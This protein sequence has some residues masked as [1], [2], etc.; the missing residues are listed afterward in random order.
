MKHNIDMV[1]TDLDGTL[2]DDHQTVN[3]K[4]FETLRLLNEV[5]IIRVIATGRNYFSVNNFF[6]EIFL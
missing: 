2:F 6:H 1:I 5:N 3:P 4:D